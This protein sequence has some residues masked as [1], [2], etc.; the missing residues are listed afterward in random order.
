MLLLGLLLTLGL[1]VAAWFFPYLLKRAIEQQS[2]ATIGRRIS[3][4]RIVLN[5][6]TG[7]YA[8]TDLV[9]REPGTDAV[10][11]S[12]SRLSVNAR[13]IHGLRTG[14]WRFDDAQLIDPYVHIAQHG[15]RFNFSDLLEKEWTGEDEPDARPDEGPSARFHV[16]GM[17][18]AG[19]VIDYDSDV[20]HDPVR[21]QELDVRCSR[22]TSGQ[23]RMEFGLGLSIGTGGRLEGG[24]TIDTDSAIYGIDATLR[25]LRL[26]PLLPYAQE[27]FACGALNGELDLDL[28]VHESYLDST[29][30]RLSAAA[31]LREVAVHDPAG[32]GLF[33]L[34]ALRATLDTMVSRTGLLRIG[35]VHIEAPSIRFE[36]FADGTDNWTRNLRVITDSTAADTAVTRVQASESNVFLLLSE[37]VSHLG[38]SFV[39]SRYTADSL[40]LVDGSVVFTDHDTPD[41]FRYTISGISLH[42]HRV[43]SEDTVAP[44]MFS[45]VLHHTGHLRATALFDPRALSNVDI[46]LALDSLTLAPFDPYMRWYAAHPL[47]DGLLRFTSR[48]IIH[49]GRLDSRN[50]L[51]IDRMRLGRKVDTH[52]PDIPVLPLRLAVSL[53]KDVRGAI[54]LE[55]PVTGDLKDPSFRVWPLVWQVVKN[56]VVKVVAAPA[57]AL[58]RSVAGVRE[59]E[60]ERVRFDPLGHA[61]AGPQRKT[62]DQLLKVLRAKPDL[63]VDLVS[64]ADE[65]SEQRTL[66]VFE[67]KRR[68][69]FPGQAVLSA[70]DSARIMDLSDQDTTFVRFVEERTPQEVGRALTARCLALVGPEEVARAWSEI[71]R[72]RGENSMRYLLEQGGD[73]ARVRMRPGTPAE[74][75]AYK[76]V[77]GYRFIFT[78]AVASEA[79]P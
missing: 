72:A 13:V 54:D 53:L 7:V 73:S 16:E 57:K 14:M 67:A 34:H 33:T 23:A 27:F 21:I 42:S 22:I 40:L 5:P 47:E 38:S 6:F 4:G 39:T 36:R 35:G 9:C 59:D 62:F 55:V 51:R 30:L 77:P 74:V 29:A 52:A 76:G 50:A 60:L 43:N 15:D 49:A 45:S 28:R 79:I 1:V 20:L 12:W 25:A 64:V 2:E 17:T 10:F 48:T 26:E 41:P 70:Q 69:L 58:V 11:V 19:G 31:A 71:E 78:D 24:F 61:P 3:I 65:A 56:L 75:A 18:I 37:Y 66:A 46:D 68:M 44:V 32:E 63:A 8:I